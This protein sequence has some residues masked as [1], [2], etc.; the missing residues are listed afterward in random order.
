MRAVTLSHA[1]CPSSCTTPVTVGNRRSLRSAAPPSVGV[2]RFAGSRRT[3]VRGRADGAASDCAGGAGVGLSGAS[4][5]VGASWDDS[6]SRLGG[7]SGCGSSVDTASTSTSSSASGVRSW[8]APSSAGGSSS[9][10]GGTPGCVACPCS[11]RRAC[12]RRILAASLGGKLHNFFSGG[13][14]SSSSS[15][16]WTCSVI[17]VTD[18]R[19][20]CV[21]SS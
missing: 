19:T 15:F 5:G 8:P 10:P 21:R 7:I 6:T 13:A 2:G 4:G 16:E 11:R 20:Y 14:C 12:C 18:G 9:S 3:M 1:P 17:V